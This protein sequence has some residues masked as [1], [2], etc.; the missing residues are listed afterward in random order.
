M[1][2][3]T[4]DIIKKQTFITDELEIERCFYENCEDILKTIMKLSDLKEKQYD[5]PEAS[6][7]D[8]IRQ[9]VDDKEAVYH[10]IN[11]NT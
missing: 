3:E 1:N 10:S 8:R 9:I 2:K 6:V 7:F 4:L 11:K 5:A